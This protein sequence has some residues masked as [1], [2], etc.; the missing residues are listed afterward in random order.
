MLTIKYEG[1]A[2]QTALGKLL[3]AIDRPQPMLHKIGQDLAESTMHRF[4]TSS[5]PDG[6]RWA[7]KSAVTRRAYPYSGAKPLVGETKALATTIR[8]QVAGHAI[9]I[10]SGQEYAAVHQF[11]AKAGSLWQGRNKRGRRAKS[12]WGDIPAR[13]YL[14]LSKQDEQSI[15]DI[16]QDYLRP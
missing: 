12:P 16:V 14:G 10:G 5:A 1:K 11:G 6:S 4:A 13:P 7:P 9:M 8:Y 15:L 2:V 3:Q